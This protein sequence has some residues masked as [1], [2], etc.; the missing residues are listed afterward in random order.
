[1]I[2]P[3]FSIVI[4]A[5]NSAASIK[6][7]LASII[8]Q[9][10]DNFEVILADGGS[11]DA[12]I[13]I[14]RSCL[15]HRLLIYSQPDRGLFDGMSRGI[16]QTKGEWVLVLGSDDELFCQ[17]T[18]E[19]AHKL[20]LQ[21]ATKCRSAAYGDAFI[22]GSSGWAEDGDTYMG[23][24]NLPLLIRKNI[25]QQAIFYYGPTIRCKGLQFD[26]YLRGNGCDHV[27]NVRLWCVQPFVYLPMTVCVFHAGGTSSF[28]GSQ[29]SPPDLLAP[30][31]WPK[32]AFTSQQRQIN[33]LRC[34]LAWK[35]PKAYRIST[36]FTAIF[37][38]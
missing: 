3:R 15:D 8:S 38:R 16:S 12:T 33:R 29:Y 34:W 19:Q 24:S 35:M 20:L 32:T 37:R 25:C 6:R 27:C 7:C 13:E 10:F 23:K 17:L 30:S 18:L 1:L 2:K 22:R 31:F 26:Q 28:R 5:L 14:A 9:T 36:L 11:S 4:P 21:H